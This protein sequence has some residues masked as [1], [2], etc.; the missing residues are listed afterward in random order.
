MSS[1]RGASA[2]A[3]E[4]LRLYVLAREERRRAKSEVL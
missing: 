1:S 2:A 3:A 4:E